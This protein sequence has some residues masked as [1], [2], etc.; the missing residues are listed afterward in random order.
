MSRKTTALDC[1]SVSWF[2]RACHINALYNVADK[3]PQT[4]EYIQQGWLSTCQSS[5]AIV[6][7]FRRV[8]SNDIT[9]LLPLVGIFDSYRNAVVALP[10]KHRELR[11]QSSELSGH[12]HCP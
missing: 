11:Q 5:A 12:A 7:A 6:C 4:V 2:R 3:L 8:L 1:M 9:K 10:E